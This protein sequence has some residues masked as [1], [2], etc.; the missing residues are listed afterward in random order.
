MRYRT[1]IEGSRVVQ[2]RQPRRQPASLSSWRRVRYKQLGKMKPLDLFPLSL[3]S[4]RD[5]DGCHEAPRAYHARTDSKLTV[6]R[7]NQDTGCY[8]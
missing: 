3:V 4:N 6:S 5:G 8:A 7:N 2:S 1:H